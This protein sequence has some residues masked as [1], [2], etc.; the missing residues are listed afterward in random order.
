[1]WRL[2]QLL[3]LM[4][5]VYAAN[6]AAPFARALPGVPRPISERWLGSH[7][8]WR[9]SLLAVLAST[10]TAWVQARL[11]WSGAVI[12]YDDWLALGLLCG[13]AAMAGDSA[14]SFVKRRLRIAPGAPWIPA[15]Q[16]D[17]VVAG[18]LALSLWHRFDWTD[19]AIVL[20]ASFVGSLGVNRLS[21]R[22]GIK[23]T[24][25]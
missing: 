7:K 5:P 10:L 2:L 15:D 11:Q 6:M 24:P 12:R 23:S 22:L 3:Y 17:Y 18:L 13:V 19:V 25:W 14:K 21:H 1:M 20:A 8:T 9:G 4:A 16:L